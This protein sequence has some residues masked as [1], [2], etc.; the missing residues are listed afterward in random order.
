MQPLNLH[1]S[2]GGQTSQKHF[3]LLVDLM[4]AE[5]PVLNKQVISIDYQ[6]ENGS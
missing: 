3:H 2:M 1:S 5:L 6:R 4:S